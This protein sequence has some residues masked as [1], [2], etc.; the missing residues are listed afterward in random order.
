MTAES[1]VGRWLHH[2]YGLSC[3]APEEVPCAF[4]LLEYLDINRIP[5]KVEEMPQHFAFYPNREPVTRFETILHA[6][7]LLLV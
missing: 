6:H 3:C 2:H 4:N 5:D 7:V 1:V